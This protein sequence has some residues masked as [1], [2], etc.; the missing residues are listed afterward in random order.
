MEGQGLTI[1][2]PSSTKQCVPFI[3]RFH[4]ICPM[5]VGFTNAVNSLYNVKEM[6]YGSNNTTSLKSLRMALINNW[7]SK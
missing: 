4:I 7:G 5:Y 3:N 1:C 6:V 2:S